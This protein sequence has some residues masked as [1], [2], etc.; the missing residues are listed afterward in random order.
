MPECIGAVWSVASSRCVRGRHVRGDRLRSL[1]VSLFFVLAGMSAI[2]VDAAPWT[3]SGWAHW[4]GSKAFNQPLLA[5]VVSV[6]DENGGPVTGLQLRN[7]QFEYYTCA[8]G[9]PRRCMYVNTKTEVPVAGYAFTATPGVYELILG[10]CCEERGYFTSAPVMARAYRFNPAAIAAGAN[11][12]FA[13]QMGQA[14]LVPAPIPWLG[15]QP[16]R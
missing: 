16:S 14:F 5:V 11:V 6:M 13:T 12:P 9:S 10:P 2:R 3:V 7:F 1:F 4:N 8:E 15:I